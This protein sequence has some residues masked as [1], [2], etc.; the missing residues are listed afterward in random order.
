VKLGIGTEA[1]VQHPLASP[2]HPIGSRPFPPAHVSL[3]SN[4]YSGIQTLRE[5]EQ[6]VSQSGANNGNVIGYM[7]KDSRYTSLRHKAEFTY[8][9]LNRLTSSIAALGRT[10]AR[11][12]HVCATRDSLNRLGSAIAALGR[13]HARGR[14]VCATR[15]K[16]IEDVDTTAG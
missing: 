5:C 9:S 4:Y 10:H 1:H 13:T 15:G 2:A 8:D 7:Y 12:R 3:I 14:H 16:V 11:G 6:Q